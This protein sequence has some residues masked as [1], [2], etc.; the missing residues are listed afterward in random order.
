MER[1]A[2][3]AI[4]LPVYNGEETLAKSIE[5]VLAQDFGDFDFLISDNCSTDATW[6]ICNHYATMDKRIRL[7]KQNK[8]IGAIPNQKFVFDNT[9][10]PYF[11]W[12]ADDDFLTSNVLSECFAAL[13]AHPDCV[14]ACAQNRILDVDGSALPSRDCDFQIDSNSVVTR[15]QEGFKKFSRNLTLPLFG[16][17]RREFLSKVS[18]DRWIRGYDF[19]WCLE[20]LMLGKFCQC[21]NTVRYYSLR[22]TPEDISNGERLDQEALQL[23][24]TDYQR[25]YFGNTLLITEILRSCR[26]FSTSLPECIALYYTVLIN[27]GDIANLIGKDISMVIGYI[28]ADSP[29][30]HAWLRNLKVHLTSK[31]HA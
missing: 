15:V 19:L 20:L 30:L 18:M 17:M 9:L 5:S 13:S 26:K 7:S 16:L 24:G 14:L 12:H 25:I 21:S 10:S 8:D 22:D 31:I 28:T 3:I 4:G 1:I 27:M 6:E 2:P 29:K 23:L 11:M